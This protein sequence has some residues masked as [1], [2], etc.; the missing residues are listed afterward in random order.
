MQTLV[1]LRVRTARGLQPAPVVK[2][3]S[4][5]RPA[6]TTTPVLLIASGPAVRTIQAALGPKIGVTATDDLE[7]ARGLAVAG[8]FVAVIA[9]PSLAAAVRGAIVVDPDKGEEAIV[10]T[11]TNAIERSHRIDHADPIAAL[12]YEEYIEHARYATTRRYLIAL[13]HQHGGSVTDAARGAKMKRESFHRL[14]R[15]HHLV[16]DHFRE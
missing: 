15:R 6:P 11:V 7:R 1:S 14:M 3:R 16:A 2:V 5:S 4:A 13:L 9:L 12:A 10:D 8:G